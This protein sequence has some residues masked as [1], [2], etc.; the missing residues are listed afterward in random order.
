MI[1]YVREPKRRRLVRIEPEPKSNLQS[2]EMTEERPFTDIFYSLKTALLK[3]FNL[4]NLGPN[5]A[6]KLRP[7]YT[8]MLPRFIGLE[9]AYFFF[10]GI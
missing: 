3:Y 6:F 9:D 5:A 7:H 4:S 1:G 10:E 2:K 8:Q